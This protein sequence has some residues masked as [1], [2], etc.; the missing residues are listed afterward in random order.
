MKIML[1]NVGVAEKDGFFVTNMMGPNWKKNFDKVR[2]PDTEIVLRVSEWGILGM[3]GFFNPAIDTLNSQLV[4]KACQTAEADGFDAILITCFGNP[5]LDQIRG[6]VNIPVM[7][8]GEA[9]MHYAA[10]MGKKFGIVHVSEKNIHECIKTVNELGF[11]EYLAGVVPTT[12][13]SEQQAEA[14]LDAHGAIEAFKT[15]GRK[16]IDMGAEVLIPACGLM[17]S[18]L[19][20][21][22][23][24]EDEFP[25]G[26]TEVDGVPVVDVLG[27]G[28]KFT[29]MAVELKRAGSPWIS[30][31]GFYSLPTE[32][33]LNSGHMCLKD[34]RQTFWDYSLT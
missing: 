27:V 14:L 20:A 26:L 31:K 29:E 8:I 5:M 9:A 22:P 21:A 18:A 11:G 12:E 34:D 17:T 15:C 7:S 19:R 4:F 32:A 23:K 16:L 33:M 13:S 6:F 28:L 30:R 3:D 10:M 2:H 25:N 1:A 24:C